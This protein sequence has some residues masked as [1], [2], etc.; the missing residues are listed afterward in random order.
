MGVFHIDEGGVFIKK[1][2][3]YQ[4]VAANKADLKSISGVVFEVYFY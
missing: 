2:G 4:S 1:I 3:I